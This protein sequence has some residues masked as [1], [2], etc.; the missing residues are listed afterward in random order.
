MVCAFLLP[1]FFVIGVTIDDKS[2]P[3][4]VTQLSS[5]RADRFQPAYEAIKIADA[6]SIL[7]ICSMKSFL[8]ER[9]EM[10]A[11]LLV[12]GNPREVLDPRT[13]PPKPAARRSCD[14]SQEW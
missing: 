9:D 14:P 5:V 2:F 1:S 3:Y 8:V 12:R 11:L 13:V 4:F 7:S 6:M 10:S